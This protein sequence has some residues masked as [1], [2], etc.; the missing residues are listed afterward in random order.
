MKIGIDIRPLMDR[1]YSGISEYTANLLSAILSAD[2]TEDYRLF[3]NSFFNLDKR[4]SSWTRTNA[5]VIGSHYPNKIFNYVG[6][7]LFHYPKIDRALGGCDIFWSPHFNFTSLSAAPTGPKK[8]ITVHDLSFLRYPEFFSWRQNFW[9]RALDVKRALREADHIIA[10]SDNTKND[11]IE[12]AGVA[13]E[14]ISVVYSGNNLERREVGRP[15]IQEFLRHRVLGPS[16]SAEN[17]SGRYILYLGNIEPRKNISG[18]IAAYNILR[19]DEAARERQASGRGSGTVKLIL[20][21]ASGWKN[22]KI[23]AAWKNS[24]YSEDI[25]FLGYVSKK[26]KEILYSLASAF[27]YPSFYEGFGFPPLEAM[28]YGLPVVCSNISSLPEVVGDGALLINPYKTEEIAEALGLIL[29]DRDIRAHFAARGYE[30]AKLFTWEKT[31]AEY[32]KIF[33]AIYEGSKKNN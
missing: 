14:K 8:I 24:P 10:V 11:I 31:A 16:S 1:Y 29:N 32:L 12:L 30:R 33:K 19:V 5:R 18:I 7:K 2:K 26:E 25:I 4:L 3:Y 21:G 23:Y 13:P 9:H 28:S 20:A 15:E 22:K 27:V 6:Q 17:D